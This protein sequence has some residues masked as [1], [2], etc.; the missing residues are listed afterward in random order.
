MISEKYLKMMKVIVNQTESVDSEFFV[1]G[2][3]LNNSFFSDVDIGCYNV[4]DK[5]ICKIKTNFE[6]SNFPYKVDLVDFS[7]VSKTFEEKV[8]NNN[9]LWI[10]AKKN[11][12]YC[13]KR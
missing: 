6:E 5:S 11:C 13:L 8:F 3:C 7:V 1:F 12:N 9:V 2:S 10:T 4:E